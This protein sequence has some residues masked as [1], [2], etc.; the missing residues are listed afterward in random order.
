MNEKVKLVT[1]IPFER[2]N[3]KKTLESI[4]LYNLS[5]MKN[6]IEQNNG[7]FFIKNTNIACC[8]NKDN[9]FLFYRFLE[10]VAKDSYN[11]NKNRLLLP[12]L[13]LQ[14]IQKGYQLKS[15]YSVYHADNANEKRLDFIGKINASTVWI[16][17]GNEYSEVDWTEDVSEEAYPV[18]ISEIENSKTINQLLFNLIKLNLEPAFFGDREDL[19][20]S[21]SMLSVFSDCVSLKNDKFSVDCEA[22]LN[23]KFT[24]GQK[25]LIQTK[26]LNS[27]GLSDSPSYEEIVNYVLNCDKRRC[28]LEKYPDSIIFDTTSDGGLWE[29]WSDDEMSKWGYK[30]PSD[31]EITA[32]NP[33]Y[34]VKDN[35]IAIDFGTS[36]TVVVKRN[37]NG[38]P[39]QM[40]VGKGDSYENPTLMKVF[41]LN[42]FLK[43]YN[44]RLGRPNTKWDDLWVSHA[45]YNE[46]AGQSLKQEEFSSIFFKLKQWAANDITHWSVKPVKERE[47]H[48]LSSLSEIINKG[49][50]NPIEVYA[51]Y[52]GL[53]INN[54][55]KDHGIYLNYYM[56]FPAKY[57]RDTKE[58]IRKSF[59]KG[60]TKS[61]PSSVFKSGKHRLSVRMNMTEPEAYAACALQVF[62]FKASE[63]NPVNYA[64]F[65][66]GG[67]TSDFAYGFWKKASEGDAEDGFEYVLENKTIDGKRYLGG[68]NLLDGLSYKVFSDDENL[69]ILERLKDEQNYDCRFD[70]GTPEQANEGTPAKIRKHLSYLQ[71]AKKNMREMSEA[72][73]PYWENGNEY[74]SEYLNNGR[75]TYSLNDIEKIVAN[76]K[77]KNQYMGLP[78]V[79]KKLDEILESVRKNENTPS[80]AWIRIDQIKRNAYSEYFPSS[81]EDTDVVYLDITLSTEETT[82][83]G[84]FG[85]PAVKL[86]YSKKK[87]YEYFKEK[88]SDGVETFFSK[89]VYTFFEANKDGDAKKRINI[90]LA[91]NSS[92]SPILRKVM[93]EKIKILC[94][95]IKSKYNVEADF[96]IYSPLGTKEAYDEIENNLKE[97]FGDKPNSS[98]IIQRKLNKLKHDAEKGQGATGKT[99][100]AFGLIDLISG[101]VKVPNKDN[102]VDKFMY[103]LGKESTD[104][105][106]MR[107]FDVFDFDESEEKGKPIIGKGLYRFQKINEHRKDYIIRYTTDAQCLGTLGL[108]IEKTRSK[109]FVVPQSCNG[110]WIWIRAIKANEIEYVVAKDI[111][112]AEKLL[113]TDV[114][115]VMHLD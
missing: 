48:E 91:G 13:K 1:K 52:I 22:M 107:I 14:E 94:K 30:I 87:M 36:S 71:P 100:V 69:S 49:D 75:K 28:D 19:V 92:K 15:V 56:S 60:L 25:S 6:L 80:A 10:K 115:K 12:N 98:E 79:E 2:E 70:Y 11:P 68:E 31:L 93:E 67:G 27:L 82:A 106:G 111:E 7:I 99:G 81:D 23:L 20:D 103:Y 85:S 77:E 53:Y 8:F 97:S 32:R 78:E 109:M 104:D 62:G 66:F 43:D 35:I 24:D 95:E 33:E 90:F 37:D 101:L 96:R 61:I 3:V 46:V 5:S 74:F 64:I 105:V 17:K 51:Y 29:L 39:I 89:L 110:Q 112:E 63:K 108:E 26:L 55:Q 88:I 86:S 113:K 58:N 84:N 40:S 54:R 34:D 83:D 21:F 16:R 59:E 45:V 57:D 44:S 65:D 76:L 50:F 4:M 47:I 72:L 114:R 18:F 73:R 41:N 102:E 42:E 38:T 9:S